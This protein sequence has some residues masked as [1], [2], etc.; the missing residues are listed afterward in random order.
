MAKQCS[1]DLYVYKLLYVNAE[2]NRN[3]I[4]FLFPWE[5]QR[6][7]STLDYFFWQL[8]AFDC[9]YNV[10]H[11]ISYIGYKLIITFPTLATN[12]SWYLHIDQLAEIY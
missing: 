2:S 5:S 11:N 7:G 3:Y 6:E 1:H 9:A 4:F 10:L 12:W 8:W